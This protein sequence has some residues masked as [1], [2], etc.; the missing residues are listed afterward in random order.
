MRLLRFDPLRDT[1]RILVVDDDEDHFVFVRDVL[2]EIPE[3]EHEVEWAKGWDEAVA[4]VGERRHHAYLVDYRL[5]AR[6]GV[7]FLEE[8]VFEDLDAPVIVFTGAGDRRADERALRA[9]ASDFLS[10]ERIEAG[11]LERA[12]RYAVQGKRQE[13]FQRF[14]AQAGRILGS[15]LDYETSA[16][17]AVRLVVPTLADWSCLFLPDSEGASTKVEAV[18]ANPARDLAVERLIELAR[19]GGPS[20]PTRK[21]LEDG[22]TLVFPRMD[23]DDLDR[24]IEGQEYRATLRDLGVAS[25]V[26]LPLRGRGRVLGALV[27]VS[28][29]PDRPYREADRPFFREL[30]RV[31]ALDLENARL[32]EAAREATR[33]RDEMLSMVSHDLGNPLAAISIAADRIEHRLQEFDDDR[34]GRYLEMIQESANSMERLLEDLLA[35]GRIDMGHFG[36]DRGPASL[37]DLLDRVQER[38][39]S[40][41]EAKQIDFRIHSDTPLPEVMIDR[42]R[43]LQV[44]SNLLHNAFKF[45]PEGGSVRVEVE[46]G[47]G[48][49]QVSVSDTGVGMTDEEKEHLFDRFW[50]ARR[51]R[52]AGAGLGLTISKEI[53]EAHGGELRARSRQGVGTTFT[54]TLPTVDAADLQRR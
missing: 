4:L 36:I 18:H 12:I 35:V 21:V 23:P 16:G 31:I 51:H 13:V 37:G 54:F 48:Q 7:E 2:Q 52:R 27:L 11:T 46:A 3:P 28:S 22:R 47:V 9:G 34:I 26:I 25:A 53:V 43:V 29:D 19:E 38:F 44:L 39:S 33:I 10:K 50:Q 32:F 41:P 17:S 45:T 5:G 40:Q 42:D 14:L 8:H 6:S 30:G 24:W 1:R 49:V 20:P 15:S